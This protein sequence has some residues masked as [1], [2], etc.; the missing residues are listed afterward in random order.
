MKTNYLLRVIAAL[1]LAL[2]VGVVSAQTKSIPVTE[3]AASSGVF[4][5][6]VMD[7]SSSTI[8]MTMSGPSDRWFGMG[9]GLTM[10]NADVLIYTDGKAG[11]MHALDVWDYDLNAQNAGGVDQDSQQDWTVSSNTVL[12]GVR[13][14]V[15]TRD[16]NTGDAIDKVLTF[17]DAT[18]D[19]IWAKGNAVSNT[20]AYHGAGNKGSTTLNWVSP[21]VTPP[22]LVVSP[23]S[24]ADEATNVLVA[25]NL[26]VTFDEDV[27][28]GTGNIILKQLSD[29]AVV[30]TF[31]VTGGLAT[32]S[33]A[34]VTINPTSDLANN[35]SY[36]VTID[37]GAIDDLAGNSYVGIADNSTWNF[38]T[39]A[40]VGIVELE[41]FIDFKIVENVL[42]I[43]NESDIQYDLKLVSLSGK[44]A[45]EKSNLVGNSTIDISKIPTGIMILKIENVKSQFTRKIAV[46]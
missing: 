41:N 24:P 35:T 9:F 44:V 5:S 1:T 26:A 18:V 19:V 43:T 3:V 29:D 16:L 15:A 42:S 27:A 8:T 17:A 34:T 25:T 38:T 46:K 11:A 22:S 32:I 2:N 36:Y 4:F 40:S 23:F 31:D 6:A 21:D 33:G 12:T 10:S 45:I 37:N 39:E 28:V 14:I 20:M 30:E 7:N 13:T